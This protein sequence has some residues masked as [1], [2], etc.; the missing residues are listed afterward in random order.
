MV[1]MKSTFLENIDYIILKDVS[2]HDFS[3]TVADEHNVRIERMTVNG[4]NG[5]E[6]YVL[7]HFPSN[8]HP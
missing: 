7:T 8:L 5:G 6:I 1:E 2:Q 3:I 4:S